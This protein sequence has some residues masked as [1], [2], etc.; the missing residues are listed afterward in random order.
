MGAT[1]PQCPHRQEELDTP[2]FRRGK[3]AGD[4]FLR[5]FAFQYLVQG[6]PSQLVVDRAAIIGIDQREM[7]QL[8]SLV[9]VGDAGRGEMNQH[10]RERVPESRP[11]DPVSERCQVFQEGP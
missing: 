1:F 6:A 8:V 4:D 3:H 5:H 11:G 7:P 9:Q 2:V 10:S